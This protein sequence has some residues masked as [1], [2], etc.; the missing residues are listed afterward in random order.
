MTLLL[1]RHATAAAHGLPGGDFVRNLVGKGQEQSQRVGRFL[2][3]HEL[4]PDVLLS[5]PV[6]RA[7]ETAKILAEE[8]CPK[9]VIEPWL[10]CG[11]GPEIALQELKAYQ[12]FNRVAIVGHEPDFSTLVEH[13]LGAETYSIRVKKAS[14]ISLELGRHPMLNF[15]IPC[16]LLK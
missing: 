11:M 13:I 12:E 4:T 6:L 1:I 8:G 9:P 7:K 3:K 15:S 2:K 5:S 10:A 16:K 14:I